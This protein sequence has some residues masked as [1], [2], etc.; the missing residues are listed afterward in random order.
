MLAAFRL[1][2][3]PVTMILKTHNQ[4]VGALIRVRSRQHIRDPMCESLAVNEFLKEHV[5]TKQRD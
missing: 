4:F 1:S 2:V 3:G 5:E